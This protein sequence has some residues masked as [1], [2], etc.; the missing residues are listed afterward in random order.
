MGW[1]AGISWE[2]SEQKPC[3]GQPMN[4][5]YGNLYPGLSS[6]RYTLV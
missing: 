4:K 5:T 2:Q 3:L 6:Q 1:R